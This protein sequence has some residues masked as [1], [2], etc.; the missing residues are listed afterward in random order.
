MYVPDY[1]CVE[2]VGTNSKEL[3]DDSDPLRM[4]F[5]NKELRDLMSEACEVV[6]NVVLNSEEVVVIALLGTGK[7]SES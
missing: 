7:K 2:S 6:D 1:T 5:P 3:T 4:V